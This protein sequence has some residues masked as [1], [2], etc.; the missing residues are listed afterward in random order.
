M[1]RF[2][3]K[4]DLTDVHIDRLSVLAAL[5]DVGKFNHG[6]Q[7]RAKSPDGPF[8]GHV[9]ELVNF[10]RSHDPIQADMVDAMGLRGIYPWFDSEQ[11][12][13]AFLISS[14]A[15]HG[16]PVAPQ[17]LFKPKLW[18]P[19][20]NR[21][22]IEGIKNL[23][24][25]ITQWF[26]EAFSGDAPSF[27]DTPEFQH[28]F[29]GILTLADWIA[30]DERFFPY[31]ET[32]DNYFEVSLKHARDAVDQLGL[33][34]GKARQILVR[35]GT[36]DFHSIAS[37]EF[38][39]RPIQQSVMDLTNHVNGSLSIVEADTGSGKTEAALLRFARLF[40][41]G[42]VDGMYF[43]LPTRTAATQ[44]HSRIVNAVERAFPDGNHRPPVLLAV[45]GYLNV[46]RMEGEKLAPFEVLWD[47]DDRWRWH[48]RGWA[49][50]NSKRYL[51]GTI[52]VGTVDQI[53]LS[54]LRVKHA[55]L[56][57]SALLRHFIVVDEVHA[58]DVYMNR[59]LDVVL[60]AHMQAGGHAML[61]SATLGSSA[62]NRFLKGRHAVVESTK[63]ALDRPYPLVTQVDGGFGKEELLDAQPVIKS[64]RIAV[65]IYPWADKPEEVAEMGLRAAEK[66]ARVLIIR[67]TVTA[68]IKT[69][70]ALMDLAGENTSHLFSANG[71][72]APH[73]ARYARSD[74]LILDRNIERYFGKNSKEEGVVAVATQ[75]VQQSLD[76]DADFMI[77]DLCP[78]DVLLQRIGRLHR[79]P[80]ERKPC[81]RPAEYQTPALATLVPKE[82]D[83]SGYIT[84]KGKAY[85][86]NGIGTVYEDLRTLEAAWQLLEH[87]DVWLIPAM[88]RQIVEEGTHPEILHNIA[89]L[90]G[91]KWIQHEEWVLGK[92][93]AQG[94]HA[95]LVTVRRDKPFGDCETLFPRELDKRIKT[96]LGTDDRYLEFDPAVVGPFGLSVSSLNLPTYWLPEECEDEALE[97]VAAQDGSIQFRFAG[98]LFI[99]DQLGLRPLD[100]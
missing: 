85:G 13:M 56:R 53:L 33:N 40:H 98:K 58:S 18:K 80:E 31:A 6:F 65:S 83:M 69:Q 55:Q 87:N 99:Y 84:G 7:N 79:H 93:S 14:F 51:A 74:R 25:K 91:E 64:K 32:T 4:D 76:L 54:A 19:Q 47:D 97:V 12:L 15:H 45:P 30:S 95:S 62:R 63:K 43:A 100:T 35:N 3:G 52:A 26:P 49:A 94:A 27:G 28:A 60:K 66:G 88:N 75:T 17:P 81:D 70:K 20:S 46:D 68:C 10:L 11:T 41:A 48:A 77:S 44:L 21:N 37:P 8:V 29:N 42:L 57:A 67:N 22:P 9:T 61:M 34:P 5:H 82:R 73:H 36:P 71:T 86:Q 59:V 78:V 72:V 24:Q 96:R 39:P 1:G 16:Q 92:R 2:Y 89:E 23:R 50:E 90:K 38:F